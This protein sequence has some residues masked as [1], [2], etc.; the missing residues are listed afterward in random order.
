MIFDNESLLLTNCEIETVGII[1]FKLGKNKNISLLLF[2]DLEKAMYSDISMNKTNVS[3]KHDFVRQIERCTENLIKYEAC[4]RS[5]ELAM[6][7]NKYYF[8]IL[9]KE[10]KHLVVVCRVAEDIID[11]NNSCLSDSPK[12]LSWVSLERFLNKFVDKNSKF[13]RIKFTELNSAFR[14]LQKMFHLRLNIK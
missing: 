11:S 5:I 6:K 12:S 10:K 8:E 1:F 3:S 7:N 4:I 2:D 13:K 14:E 9:N